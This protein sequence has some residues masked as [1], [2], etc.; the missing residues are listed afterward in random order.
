MR[1]KL[2]IDIPAMCARV[3]ESHLATFRDAMRGAR[4]MPTTEEA[5]A[6]FLLAA[7]RGLLALEAMASDNPASVAAKLERLFDAAEEE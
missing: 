4:E 7:K 1:A 5:D 6:L 2:H 3:A